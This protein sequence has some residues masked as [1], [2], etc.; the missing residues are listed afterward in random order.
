MKLRLSK[1]DK[2]IMASGGLLLVIIIVYSQF[3]S[4]NP[5]KSDLTLK[6]QE[7]QTEQKLLDTVTQKM[8]LQLIL[9]QKILPSFRSRYL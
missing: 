4:L 7:L 3:F 8:Q 1:M 2:I 9:N 5:L 6:E